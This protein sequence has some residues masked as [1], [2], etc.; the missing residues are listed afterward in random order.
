MEE[1]DI[2][3]RDSWLFYGATPRERVAPMEMYG[4]LILLEAL[5]N[6]MLV[7]STHM[8]HFKAGT[9]NQGNSMSILNTR[10]KSWPSSIILMQMVWSAHE[11]NIELGI[12]HIYRESNTWADQLAGGDVQGFDP[13]KRLRT[14]MATNK[15]DLLEMF[16]TQEALSR[17]PR[18]ED[19]RRPRKE[20]QDNR[21]EQHCTG[22]A[23]RSY[24]SQWPLR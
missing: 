14:S 18:T 11:H 8:M 16:T 17:L 13:S 15:W 21:R 1:F 22:R 6:K 12:R 4:T 9:D 10:S 20:N 7:P 19:R 2:D 3:G 23:R 24:P 5:W